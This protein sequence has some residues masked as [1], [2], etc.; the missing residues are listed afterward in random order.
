[1]KELQKQIVV[2]EIFLPPEGYED[3]L[4]SYGPVLFDGYCGE[5]VGWGFPIKRWLSE[6]TFRGL[7]AYGRLECLRPGE[8]VLVVRWLT[9]EEAVQKYGSV[10][11]TEVG[12]RGGFRSI[13][14]GDK[15]F[16][17][18]QMRPTV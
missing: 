16:V 17:H 1:M 5:P 15:K 11:K 4:G 9:E 14:Y 10:T 7:G 3:A 18:R 2:Q 6:E 8:W 13:T 12:P